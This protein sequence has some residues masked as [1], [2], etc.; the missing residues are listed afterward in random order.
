RV[1]A[2]SDPAKWDTPETSIQV[3]IN[4]PFYKTVWAYLLY[5][6][7][8]L[9]AFL[10]FRSHLINKTRR[11]NQIRMERVKTKKEQ[12]FY[13]EKIEFFIAM[14]HEIRTPLSLIMAPLEKLL[15]MKKWD[16]DEQKQLSV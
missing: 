12:E 13:A 2:S 15:N 9:A 4:P 6:F 7:L 10:G 16:S 3:T 1:K 11:E 14:A 8:G 5:C